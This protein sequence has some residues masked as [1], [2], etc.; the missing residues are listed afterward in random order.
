MARYSRRNW[1]FVGSASTAAAKDRALATKAASTGSRRPNPLRAS[2]VDAIAAKFSKGDSKRFGPQ[3]KRG[4]GGPVAPPIC[5]RGRPSPPTTAST[6]QPT[7]GGW[8]G[9]PSRSCRGGRR[10]EGWWGQTRGRWGVALCGRRWWPCRCT[11]VRRSGSGSRHVQAPAC[12]TW[13]TASGTTA[14]CD[15]YPLD[16]APKAIEKI[17]GVT[18]KCN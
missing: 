15:W 11:W 10:H 1:A 14:R 12:G 2:I 9:L 16:T 8:T 17:Q 18:N 7:A 5:L 3:E 13:A 4:S 6:V